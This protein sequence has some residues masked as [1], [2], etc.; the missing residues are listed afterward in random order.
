MLDIQQLR[1][2]LQNIITR[3]AQRG[4]DFP[5]ADFE[6]LESQRKS[7]QTLTQTLQAKRNSASKQIGIARQ[8]GEDV[9]LIMAEVA[10]MGDELKQAENQLEAVQ[11]RL[12]QL[13]LEIPN[14]PHD[15]V[16]AGKDENDN[17]EMRRWGPRKR[18]IF[19]YR[20][21]PALV[22]TSS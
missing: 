4:Y 11:T 16:P 22:N 8:R 3:L 2:N 20:I 14:L 18:L 7:V 1:S 10:N 9:S 6:S 19:R 5:V 12:Q 15:S 21:M 13:L 17:L